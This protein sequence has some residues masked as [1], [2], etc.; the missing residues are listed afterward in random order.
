MYA[1]NQK[2]LNRTVKIASQIWEAETGIPVEFQSWGD[3]EAGQKVYIQG[4]SYPYPEQIW[5]GSYDRSNTFYPYTEE[6][7]HQEVLLEVKRFKKY[8]KR[9]APELKKGVEIRY[10]HIPQY[11]R[12]PRIARQR[13]LMRVVIDGVTYELRPA[14]PRDENLMWWDLE[15]MIVNGRIWISM[16]YKI[17]GWKY[18]RNYYYTVIWG[19][20]KWEA[21]K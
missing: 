16:D 1:K 20:H 4:R 6:R 15:K 7:I 10:K 17:A 11:G 5:V 14:Y 21:P 18:P 12:H 13:A 19:V 9:S 2:V 8:L 3:W